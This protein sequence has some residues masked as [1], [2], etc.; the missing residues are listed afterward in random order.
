MRFNFN[1]FLNLSACT[2]SNLYSSCYYCLEVATAAQA[3]RVVNRL[4]KQ[5]ILGGI[6]ILHAKIWDASSLGVKA[7][8]VPDIPV[9]DHEWARRQKAGRRHNTKEDL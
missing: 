3:R 8:P 1:I 9:E 5:T 4:H 7:I 2:Q 6:Y